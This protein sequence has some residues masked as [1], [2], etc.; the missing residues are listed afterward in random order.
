VDQLTT[1]QLQQVDEFVNGYVQYVDIRIEVVADLSHAIAKQFRKTPEVTF[2]KVLWEL[3]H[4][5]G[6]KL[7]ALINSK[8]KEMRKFWVKRLLIV[9]LKFFISIPMVVVIASFFSML[10]LLSLFATNSSWA[11]VIR[12]SVPVW[13]V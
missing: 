8:K 11:D 13:N 4:H 6:K 1:K 10:L 9:T 5:K 12:T 2:G 3:G 7:K